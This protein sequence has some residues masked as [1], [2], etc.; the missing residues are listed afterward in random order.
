MAEEVTESPTVET[1][2]ESALPE[3]PEADTTEES[4]GQEEEESP[5]STDES[6]S[7]DETEAAPDPAKERSER[8]E[9]TAKRQ[10]IELRQLKRKLRDF[11][12]QRGKL[13]T[14][15]MEDPPEPDIETYSDAEVFKK[16][17]AEWKSKHDAYVINRDRQAQQQKAAK[18]A[19][20]K[21]LREHRNAWNKLEIETKA[22]IPEYTS[23]DELYE[24]LQPNEIL[25][26]FIGRQKIG[27]DILWHLK[28]NPEEFD[29]INSIPDIF[30]ATEELIKLRDTLS[31][32]I[33]GIKPKTPTTK[34]PNAVKGGASGPAKQRSAADI[35]YG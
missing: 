34:P 23:V 13:E 4:T 2:M 12:S 31:N 33:K 27:P 21:Q 25:G 28:Q 11:E 3:T 9:E 10:A 29:R 8:A 6:E 26:G 35:L 32:Q 19:Q 16:D 7:K 22:R 15:K 30:E 20:E 5:A 1:P 14:P 17:H 24:E 18:E